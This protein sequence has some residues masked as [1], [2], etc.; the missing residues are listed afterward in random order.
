MLETTTIRQLKA[1][2]YKTYV[3]E[4]TR[5]MILECEVTVLWILVR[6]DLLGIT[7]CRLQANKIDCLIPGTCLLSPLSCR[8]LRGSYSCFGCCRLT[9]RV[10]CALH[11]LHLQQFP[12]R[13]AHIR[14]TL[15][16][17]IYRGITYH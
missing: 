13:S 5:V 4:I 2:C 7:S 14:P 6:I 15:G 1:S 9:V 8:L 16:M 17:Y 12:H 11:V 3:S 10:C